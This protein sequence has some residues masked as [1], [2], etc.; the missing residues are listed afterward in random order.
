MRTGLLTAGLSAAFAASGQR[1]TAAPAATACEQLVSLPPA[2][3]MTVATDEEHRAVGREWC[4]REVLPSRVAGRHR[5][6]RAGTGRE[7]F[8]HAGVGCAFLDGR[9]AQ[10]PATAPRPI[11]M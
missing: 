10:R 11:R 4:D 7:R 2:E 3:R 9:C 6:R 8:Q 1:A 5:G